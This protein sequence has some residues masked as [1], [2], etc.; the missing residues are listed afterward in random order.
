MTARDWSSVRGRRMRLTRVDECG[1]IESGPGGMLVTK[2]FVQVSYGL[3]V[4][5]G[6][7]ISVPDAGG[8]L[9]ISEPGTPSVKWVNVEA[10]FCRIDPDAVEMFTGWPVVLDGGGDGV[11]W[12]VQKSIAASG[13][14]LEVWSDISGTGGVC[15]GGD[16]A[17]GYFLVPWLNNGIMGDVTIQ[18]GEATFTIRGKGRSGSPWGTGPYLVD[19]DADGD[20]SKLLTPIGPDDLMDI[21]LTTVAPPAAAAGAQTLTPAA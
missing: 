10:Q 3:E 20:P 7:E 13:V 5:E 4:D 8:D 19:K 21:H 14:G 17:Y 16:K 18:N 1:A 2:G 6:T 11:G 9:C 15:S 12:R